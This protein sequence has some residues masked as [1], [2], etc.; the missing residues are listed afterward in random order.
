[1]AR[2]DPK[3]ASMAAEATMS[4]VAPVAPRRYRYSDGIAH[5]SAVLTAPETGGPLP[6]LGTPDLNWN[7]IWIVLAV[8]GL[9]IVLLYPTDLQ[10]LA[11]RWASD[12]GWSHGIVVPLIAVFFVRLKWDTLCQL[13][14]RES[15]WGVAV[16]LAGVMGQVLFRATGLAYMSDLSL[17]VVLLGVLLF[18]F[19]WEHLKILWLPVSYLGFAIP[20]PTP[21]YVK[22]TMP[23]QMLAAELGVQLLPVFGGEG[24]R[25]G[26]VLDVSFGGVH[27]MLNVE[28][29]CSGMR[30]LVAFFALAVALAYSTDRPTWQKVTLAA[31]A[32]PIAIICNGLRVTMTGYMAVKVNPDWA[33]GSAHEYFGLLM[34]GPAL[35]MQLAVA[36]VLDRLFVEVP[37]ERKRRP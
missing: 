23:M 21:L 24:V 35:L 30:M 9:L 4:P 6:P 14:P 17:M 32:L 5:P 15:L 26:T 31:C 20:P 18:V 19:G 12:A 8:V 13:T 22:V 34:L 25:S 29:A 10:R 33:H 28:Q 37:D 16:L 27:Q 2:E 3:L 7:A 11:A 1:M 36:W